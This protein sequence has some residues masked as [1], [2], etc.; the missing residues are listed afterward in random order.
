MKK[1]T[2]ELHIQFLLGTISERN[3]GIVMFVDPNFCSSMSGAMTMK[4]PVSKCYNFFII[5]IMSHNG[6]LNPVSVPN[7]A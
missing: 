4:V 2:S 3:K 1:N 5:T 7:P 6:S